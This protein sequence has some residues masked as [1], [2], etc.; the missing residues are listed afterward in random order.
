M[1]GIMPSPETV[2]RTPESETTITHFNGHGAVPCLEDVLRALAQ[3]GRLMHLTLVPSKKEWQA[4]FRETGGSGYRVVIKP[5]PVEALLAA[6]GPRW[7]DTWE[8]HLASPSPRKAPKTRDVKK[9]QEKREKS[10]FD[11]DIEDLL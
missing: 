7:G 9:R 2:V 8:Q 11:E 4:S 10:D 1:D 3:S 5:D 6:L